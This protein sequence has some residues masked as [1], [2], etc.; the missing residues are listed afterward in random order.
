VETFGL[1]TERPPSAAFVNTYPPRRCGIATFA[2]DLT[3]AISGRDSGLVHG[4]AMAVDVVAVDAERRGFPAEVRFRLDPDVRSEYLDTARRLNERAYDVVSVQHEFGIYG[5]QDG[6]W[7]LDLLGALD[8]PI[9]TTLHTVLAHPSARQQRIIEEIGKLSSRVVVLSRAAASRLAP[10]YRLNTESVE[11]VP[12]GVP[13]LPFVDPELRKPEFGLAGRPTL[14]SFG[15]LGP[16]KGFELAIEAMT[17]VVARVPDC[18]YVIL[19]STHPELRRREGEQ[20][21]DRLTVL[22][23]ERGL[24]E[25]VRFVDAFVDLPTLGRWLQAADVYVTPYPGA[26]QVVSGTLAYALGAGK[27]L[28]STPYAYARELLADGRG[29]LVPFGDAGA[30]GQAVAHFLSDQAA[31]DRARSLAYRYGRSMTWA[32]VGD[33]YR[34]IFADVAAARGSVQRPVQVPRPR[35]GPG[36]APCLEA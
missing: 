17:T 11:V 27:A 36:L 13:D 23:R 19:G 1:R 18:I 12:H 14:L 28:V 29:Q 10:I 7:I 21:R 24:A 30:L 15:L 8:A 5:G 9:V 31:R 3:I 4:R 25:H 22:V 26:E 2:Q 34:Q 35:H 32:V 33:R 16:G 6:E 20:Y